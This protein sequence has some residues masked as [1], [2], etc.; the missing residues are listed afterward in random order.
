MA[1]M[2]NVKLSAT[3]PAVVQ[4]RCQQD[5]GRPGP[6]QRRQIIGMAHPACRI[7]AA[8]GVQPLHVRKP[9]QIGPGVH[10]NPRQG[11]D[12]YLC[13]PALGVLQ[14]GG[15]AE[16]IVSP[17]I[18]RQHALR[19]P[20]AMFRKYYQALATQHRSSQA[21]FLPGSGGSRIGKTAIHPELQVRMGALQPLHYTSMI[22]PLKNGI[23]IGNINP[24]KRVQGKQPIHHR[25]GTTGIAQSRFQRL[26][27]ITPASISAHNLSTHQI[28]YRDKV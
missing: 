18:Q 6:G 13:R 12:N 24:S 5:A 8:G 28:E 2:K 27:F 19:R 10:A 22:A 25:L 9:G 14:Q 11:H 20:C 26:I 3:E 7:H 17:K 15:R 21:R 16:K 4:G 1:R 23:Q